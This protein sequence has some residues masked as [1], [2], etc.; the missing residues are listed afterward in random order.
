M[1]PA[2]M[3]FIFQENAVRQQRKCI[4]TYDPRAAV[5]TPD[6]AIGAMFANVRHIACETTRTRKKNRDNARKT[7]TRTRRHHTEWKII[8]LTTATELTSP[9]CLWPPNWWHWRR[10][11]K[12]SRSTEYDV[13]WSAA[14]LSPRD[15]SPNDGWMDEHARRSYNYA[16]VNSSDSIGRPFVLHSHIEEW[17]PHT[18]K[19]IRTCCNREPHDKLLRH[20]HRSLCGNL[21]R[22]MEWH[23]SFFSGAQFMNN[24]EYVD[25]ED[26]IRVRIELRMWSIIVHIYIRHNI[27][28][29]WV[30]FGVVSRNESMRK[31]E[32]CQFIS[33]EWCIQIV[34]SLF[35]W[36]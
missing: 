33:V 11:R 32:I 2:Y 13:M 23:N 28:Y 29:R 3:Y 26:I 14:D 35:L 22:T 24:S 34:F 15:L 6:D 36:M 18:H 7:P 17:F 16:V 31:F 19:V 9:A 10:R 20:R 21:V 30:G 1:W 8:H 27:R 4:H 12:H 25:E 5:T